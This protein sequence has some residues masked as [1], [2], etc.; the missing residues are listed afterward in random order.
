MQDT[1]KYE[2]SYSSE[3][4]MDKCLGVAKKLGREALKPALLL[5]YVLQREDLPVATRAI[6]IGALG[7][8]ISPIDAVPDFVPIVGLSDDLA[9]LAGALAAVVMYVDK[10][11]RDKAEAKL[12]DWFG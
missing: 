7:Y 11:V 4:M 5:Y 8:F 1:S 9:I 6:I 3:K 10:D 12:Q 2:S